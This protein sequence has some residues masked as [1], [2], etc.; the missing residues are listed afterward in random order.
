MPRVTET[1]RTTMRNNLQQIRRKY[2]KEQY[3]N[4]SFTRV[5]R[6][7]TRAVLFPIMHHKKGSEMN[8]KWSEMMMLVCSKLLN[9]QKDNVPYGVVEKDDY[10]PEFVHEKS[11]NK[12]KVQHIINRVYLDKYKTPELFWKDLGQCIRSLSQSLAEEGAQKDAQVLK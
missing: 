1:M 4:P 8:G 3:F 5:D 12:I 7:L 9:Y 2:G 6:I 11:T 10:H